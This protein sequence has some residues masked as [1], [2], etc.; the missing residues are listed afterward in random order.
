M[1][2]SLRVTLVLTLGALTLPLVGATVVGASA[3]P[4][5]CIVSLSP[6]ATNTLF[7]I[8]AG[9]QVQAV[10]E[11]S[12]YPAAALALSKRHKINAL[13]P[14]L[15]AILGICKVSAHHPS[16]KPDLVI[17][18]YDPSDFQQKLAA[19]GIKVV[20]EN[21]ATSVA[22]A[23]A[24]IR[25]IG[26]LTGHTQRADALAATM[27]RTIAA[28]IASVPAHPKKRI[29]VFYEI[30]YNPYY[31]LTSSTFVGS[32]MKKMGV[33]NIADGNSTTTAAGYP[34]LSPEYILSANPSLIFLA[35]DATAASVATRPG[36]RNIAAVK[37]GNVVELNADI[38]S[39]WGPRLVDLVSQIARE[40]KHVEGEPTK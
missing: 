33:I 8:G 24:Q 2:T 35:G 31:S 38:A 14:S 25:Q 26:A 3:A 12:N 5:Q 27:N 21:A 11:Y 1:F 22:N 9:S 23:L 15:E 6:T 36:F 4:P 30:T 29:S 32:I 39:Q 20:Q 10:D 19:Q 7:A 16:T 17:I 40:V 37:E 28:E 18:S 13:S 34:E